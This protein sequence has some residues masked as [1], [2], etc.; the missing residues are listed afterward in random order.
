MVVVS[1]DMQVFGHVHPQDFGRNIVEGEAS[2]DF[3]FPRSG[4]Y[5][6]S[7]DAMTG[8]GAL[9]EHFT[10][11]VEGAGP[12]PG[13]EMSAAARVLVVEAA[14]GDVYTSPVL[15]DQPTPTGGYELSVSRPAAIRAGDEVTLTW[16]YSKDGAP[17]TDLRLFL[18]AAMHLA[19]VKDDLGRFVHGHGVPKGIA[20]GFDHAHGPGGTETIAEAPEISYFGP[21]VFAVVTFPEPGRYYLFGQAAHG[22]R[23]LF[24]RIP[25]D[26]DA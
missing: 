19:V 7:A 1:E 15:F 22:N 24:S 4:R 6:A 21:E 3:S 18:E 5:L 11:T 13:A 12:V 26:V 20:T 16:R 25:V 2:V 17:I 10:V 14:E 8:D 23:L 9:A